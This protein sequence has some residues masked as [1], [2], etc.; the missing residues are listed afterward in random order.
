EKYAEIARILGF[1]GRTERDRRDRLF[2]RVDAL[3]AEVEQPRTLADCAVSRKEFDK[4]L[5]D[6][7]RAAF[8]DPSIRTNPRIPMIRE[9]IELLEAGYSGG[10]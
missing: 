1:G 6:L 8:M 2:A 7:A 3:L 4:A 9:V 5:P 10:S